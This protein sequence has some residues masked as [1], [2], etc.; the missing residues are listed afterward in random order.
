MLTELS[1][2][3]HLS[4]TNK[5]AATLKQELK[6]IFDDVLNNPRIK[7]NYETLKDEIQSIGASSP[8]DLDDELKQKIIEFRKEVHLQLA[9]ALKS[10]DLDVKFVRA[11]Q[12]D[13]GDEGSLSEYESKFE[14]LNKDIEKE[15]EY[16]VNSSDIKSNIEIGGCEGWRHT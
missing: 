9:N 4:E 2:V 6:T 13:D 3:K 16:S 14:E 1:E 11:K 7:E 15:I 8:S 5:E 10:A 12:R